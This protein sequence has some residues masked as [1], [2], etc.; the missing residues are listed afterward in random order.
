MQ[1]DYYI[2][3][4]IVIVF[5]SSSV[6]LLTVGIPD[7]STSS[8]SSKILADAILRHIRMAVGHSTDVAS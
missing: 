8:S 2:K 5:D 6:V 1:I 3:T 7:K 4:F